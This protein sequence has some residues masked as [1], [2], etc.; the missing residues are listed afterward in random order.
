MPSSHPDS[1]YDPVY[2]RPVPGVARAG[3][4]RPG[5]AGATSAEPNRPPRAPA[6]AA[7]GAAGAREVD[8]GT[9]Q[10]E[11][12]RPDPDAGLGWSGVPGPAPSGSVP[13]ST[14]P[15]GSADPEAD[16][17]GSDD[18]PRRANPFLVLLWLTAAAFAAAA[19]WAT[20]EMASAY[21]ATFFGVTIDP[22]GGETTDG[23]TPE[24][25]ARLQY[26]PSIATGLY[27]AAGV[28]LTGALSVHAALWDRARRT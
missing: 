15:S 1:R 3:Q 20:T 14:E 16:P 22:G 28:A 18:A 7:D 10:A 6:P 23:L 5:H 17:L 25:M 26:L 24:R 11:S 13:S 9:A 8:A 21:A 19:V 2:Q 27:V 12:G 4:P